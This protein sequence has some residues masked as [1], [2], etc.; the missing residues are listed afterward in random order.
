[1]HVY[2]HI[3]YCFKKCEYCYFKSWGVGDNA[4]NIIERYIDG[5]CK[6]IESCA[7]RPDLADKTIRSLYIG[8][9]TPSMLSTPQLLRFVGTL[10]QSFDFSD[11]FQEFCIEA[12]PND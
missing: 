10:K 6:E 4:I 9:G 3:P 1:M 7:R 5:S 11:N 12:N 2:V 8:G